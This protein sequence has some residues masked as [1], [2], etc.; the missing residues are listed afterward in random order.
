MFETLSMQI[1]LVIRFCRQVAFHFGTDLSEI[2]WQGKTGGKRVTAPIQPL[3]LLLPDLEMFVYIGIV[4]FMHTPLEP[5][6]KPDKTPICFR[7]YKHESYIYASVSLRNFILVSP[8]RMVTEYAKALEWFGCSWTIIA[9]KRHTF[10]TRGKLLF[11]LT[12]STT[13]RKQ[14]RNYWQCI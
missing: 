12:T 13:S 9:A 10:R 5:C 4:V 6:F 11:H 14:S 3:S 2:Y 8:Q 1:A 7:I